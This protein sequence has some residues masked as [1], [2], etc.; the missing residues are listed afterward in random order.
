[1]VTND[2]EHQSLVL[3]R[4]SAEGLHRQA[5]RLSGLANSVVQRACAVAAI[6][7][8]DQPRHGFADQASKAGRTRHR[9]GGEAHESDD[10]GGRRAEWPRWPSGRATRSHW[11]V[12]KPQGPPG[13]TTDGQ[14]PDRAHGPTEEC[15]RWSPSTPVPRSGP[16]SIGHP[17]D[18]DPRAIIHHAQARVAMAAPSLGHGIGRSR[19]GHAS[20]AAPEKSLRSH[21]CAPRAKRIWS[22]LP[23]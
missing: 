1:M 20:D 18:R 17:D 13:S 16:T 19:R 11:G 2:F 5:I 9:R 23:P 10:I 14:R 6:G 3:F 7:R 22:L 4:T 21:K 12:L 15:R 8:R